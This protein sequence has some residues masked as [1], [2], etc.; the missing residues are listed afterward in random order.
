MSPHYLGN[1]GD[2]GND[3]RPCVSPERHH[4]AGHRGL[5]N[6][7]VACPGDHQPLDLVRH[8]EHLENA[9]T[10][11]ITRAVAAAAALAVE[12]LGRRRHAQ[13]GCEL[14][15][16]LRGCIADLAAIAH[17]TDQPLRNDRDHRG[18]DQE[19][20]DAHVG[21]PQECP[22]RV[23]RVQRRQHQVTGEGRLDRDLRGLAVADLSDQD[24]V[25]VLPEDG[26]EAV[27]EGD[28]GQ[29]VDLA[30]V[31]VLEHVLDRVFDRHDVADLL[32]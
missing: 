20:L 9:E 27:R 3:L 31:D 28:V 14:D 5:L 16:L 29:L 18:G 2:S 13:G 26:P 22:D 7:M 21:E 1:G 30:L 11:E 6:F 25:G 23:C 19:A 32:V 17:L 10:V 15:V 24:D 4:P 8:G 12:Q